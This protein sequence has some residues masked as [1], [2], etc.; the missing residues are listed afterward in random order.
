MKTLIYGAGPLGSL[1]AHLL[2]QAGKD[3]TLLARNKRYDFLK[4]N[5]V[6]LVNEFTGE[7]QASKVRVVDKLADEDAYDLIVVLIRKNKLLPVFQVLSQ[8]KD[9]RNILFM[10]NN[11]LG[12]DEYLDHLPGGKVLFG[13]PGAGG[14]RKE[15]IVHYIDSEKPG[16]K[17]MPI[18][19]GEIDGEVKDRTRQIKLL[20]ESSG[21]PVDVVKDMDG[22]LK[23]HA[24][25][26][27]PIACVL[28]KHDC[29]NYALAK[30]EESTPLF[31]RA[32][33][34]GG[35]VLRKLGYTKRQP[36]KFNL[37]YWM[38]EFITTK[39]FKGIFNTKYA[40]IG[41]AMHAKAALDEMKELT[42][43]FKILIDKSC[44][45]TPIIDILRS[46]I[47]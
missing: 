31:I 30:N 35:D 47:P 2:H 46:Y 37:F 9:V 41:F 44:V 29:D 17:R 13:F 3:V 18:R 24:A 6:V 27:C 21:V 15:Q 22:W 16:G 19:I 14:S 10:G 8:N 23:Y 12:F 28:Y 34:E 39:I 25:L 4:E 36:F 43:E 26:V 5:G 11:A 45:K 38:P 33:R 7:K 20:F 42:K 40:E 1:Y 32:C